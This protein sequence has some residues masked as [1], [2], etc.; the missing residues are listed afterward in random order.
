MLE[1]ILVNDGQIYGHT[2]VFL[3]RTQKVATNRRKEVVKS[4]KITL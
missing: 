1:I 4:Q 2:K 3:P